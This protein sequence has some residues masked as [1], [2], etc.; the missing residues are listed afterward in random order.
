MPGLGVLGVGV[1]DLPIK[2]RGLG[3]L[4]SAMAGNRVL[5][6]FSGVRH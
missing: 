1:E 2:E 6:Q 3:E 5:E 4:P